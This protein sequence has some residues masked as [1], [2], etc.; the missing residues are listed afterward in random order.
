MSHPLL[1]LTHGHVVG[2]KACES[3]LIGEIWPE[4]DGHEGAGGEHD[5]LSRG[6]LCVCSLLATERCQH[7]LFCFYLWGQ[8]EREQ[9]K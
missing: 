2:I 3:L 5:F 1:Q 9:D 4:S 6:L 7:L 8:R